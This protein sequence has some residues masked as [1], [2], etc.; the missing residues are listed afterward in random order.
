[1]TDFLD[2]L[3]QEIKL[4]PLPGRHEND[5]DNFFA[6]KI[7]HKSN[8][9]L[10]PISQAAFSELLS[11][12]AGT[13]MFMKIIQFFNAVQKTYMRPFPPLGSTLASFGKVINKLMIDR[14]EPLEW[15]FNNLTEK[16]FYGNVIA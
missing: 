3:K 6:P 10:D 13:N 7:L 2:D 5:L 1:M 8:N 4:Y 11:T 9:S 12:E 14:N 16:I 15:F